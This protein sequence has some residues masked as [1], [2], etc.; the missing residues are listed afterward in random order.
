MKCFN[1]IELHSSVSVGPRTV[2][3]QPP[4]S[5]D[6]KVVFLVS[7]QTPAIAHRPPAQSDTKH[8]L[9][10]WVNLD[11]DRQ[12]KTFRYRITAGG[13]PVTEW[14]NTSQNY[15]EVDADLDD[16]QTCTAEVVAVDY[17]EQH[18]DVIRGSLVIDSRPPVL[19]GVLLGMEKNSIFGLII[20]CVQ[21]KILS[22]SF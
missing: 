9:L 14:R 4:S 11:D 15:A 21:N 7:N 1:Q 6:G 3:L 18:S 8:L 22:T 10:S 12:L 13:V 16:G 19:T 2:L 20:Y 17:R 5:R